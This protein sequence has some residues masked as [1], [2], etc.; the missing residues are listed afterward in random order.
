[1]TQF[2]LNL[3][4]V[5]LFK[6]YSENLF[7]IFIF[8]PFPTLKLK[9]VKKIDDTAYSAPIPY[10]GISGLL[11]KEIYEDIVVSL[12]KDVSWLKIG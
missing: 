7:V 9:D 3:Y 12:K 8:L 6:Y 5:Y 11:C 2:Q 1:M 4:T 10:V